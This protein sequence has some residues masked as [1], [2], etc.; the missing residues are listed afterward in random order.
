MMDS[1]GWRPNHQPPSSSGGKKQR[2]GG[3]NTKVKP[4]EKQRHG[5]KNKGNSLPGDL[6]TSHHHQVEEKTK[7]LV[8]REKIHISHFLVIFPALH[9]IIPTTYLTH[10]VKYGCF[11]YLGRMGWPLSTQQLN[12]YFHRACWYFGFHMACWY[13]GRLKFNNIPTSYSWVAIPITASRHRTD[14]ISLQ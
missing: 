10:E 13:F 2:T 12:W 9:L 8:E 5:A 6:I 4:N 7:E 14:L 11:G 3:E 1:P